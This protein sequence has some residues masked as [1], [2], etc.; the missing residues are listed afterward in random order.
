[1][2]NLNLGILAHVDAGKT[3]LTERLLHAA[4][5]IAEVGRVD[6]GTTRTD[7]LALER[8]RGITIRSAV[9]SFR[10]GDVA[11]NLIDTPGHPDFIAEVERVLHVLDGAV[12]V[13][14]AVEGVQAQTR[15]LFRT[16]RRLG[17]PTLL[18]VNKID[19][20]GA[21]YDDLLDDLATVLTP[22]VVPLATVR[23]AGTRRAEAVPCR[24]DD[25]AATARLLD[26]LA[27]V[28]DHLLADYVR[29]GDGL[30][31]ARL[32]RALARHSR[33]GRVF[34]ALFGS[35]LTGA[36][37]DQLTAALPRLL[38]T[39]GGD[40]AGPLAASVFTVDRGPAGEKLAYV[41]LFAGT[42]R[43]RAR[44]R[45]GTRVGTVTGVRVFDQ[46]GPVRRDE[47]QAGQIA[48]LRGLSDVRIGDEL[49]TLDG[50]AR[51][52]R[53]VRLFA[54]PS[55]E[56]VVVAD[57]PADTGAL[58]AALSTLAE[59]D[60][61][62]NLRPNG[63][64]GELS[65]SLYGEVQKEV[66][67]AMLAEEFGVA[68]MFRESTTV[69]VERL[70]GSGAAVEVIAPDGSNPFL[71]TV[72]LRVE[73]G[74]VGGGVRFRLGVERGSLPAAFFAA[75]EETVHR[76]LREGRYGWAVLDCLVTM[77]HSGYVSLAS[78]AGDFRKL[79]PL[80]LMAALARAGTQVHEP[81]HHF[82]VEAP[83]DTVGPVLAALARARAVTRG[84]R[85][86]GGVAHLAGDLPAAR[87]HGLH[88][89]LPGL[90]RGE[91]VLETT[92]DRWEPVRGPV[93]SRPRTDH[94]PLR[95]EEYLLRVQRLT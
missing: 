29:A 95:R 35:A 5:V 21:R 1:V 27:D 11:V 51:P 7:T 47:V 81:I 46:G 68:V 70:V 20:V 74:P 16:L 89:D 63:R 15:A 26:V 45:H 94:N 24:P 48:L 49:S 4:G 10:V 30:P 43:N 40:P 18:F 50:D 85:V 69:C 76:T 17:I 83:A 86:R 64:S 62:I 31:P 75:V 36:G 87:I 52:S 80:V 42:L 2:R 77:T 60:P 67:G 65:L 28:D 91:G 73:P 78:T 72:G 57:R 88:R 53:A 38:P 22:A 41:R 59:R 58:H 34:P 92:F 9:V 44:L 79:T 90:T 82:G 54:P 71:A 37:I 12:L 61:L 25:P 23:R 13:V 84:S 66:I 93:P 19:R 39:A 33:A 14:S 56:T 55:L 3:S 8:R 32:R 6:T